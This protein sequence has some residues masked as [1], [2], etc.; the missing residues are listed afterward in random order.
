MEYYLPQR[1]SG[2]LAPLDPALLEELSTEGGGAHH[3]S[4]EGLQ[5]LLHQC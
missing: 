3:M 4:G 2:Q 5:G 1:S